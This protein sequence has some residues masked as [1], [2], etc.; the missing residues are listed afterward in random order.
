MHQDARDLTETFA[1]VARELM[2]Q[3]DLLGTLER[4]VE[5]AVETIDGCDFAGLSLIRGREIE[6]PAQSDEMVAVADRLQVELGEGPCLSAIREEHT[7]VVE[8]LTVDRRWPTWGPR[9][10]G[11]LGVRSMLAFQLYNS[12]DSLG[13]LNLYSKRINAFDE[14]A[15]RMGLVFASHAAVAL[16]GAQAQENLQ[17][18]V[19]TRNV[20]GQAQGI[21]MERFTVAADKAFDLLRRI[22]QNENIKLRDVAV[23][24]VTTGQAPGLPQPLTERSGPTGPTAA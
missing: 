24:L 1:R 11:E 4:I 14:D 2:H 21:L 16:T 5:L 13:A 10:C 9:V 8:D 12:E 23:R 7:V 19:Q 17:R 22:S 6:S 18:A 15:L 20:I 3:G